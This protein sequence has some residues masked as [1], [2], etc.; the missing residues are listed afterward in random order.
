MSTRL[1]CASSAGNA[2]V[3]HMD[4][5]QESLDLKTKARKF[6]IEN[7]SEWGSVFELSDHIAKHFD[8]DASLI[9]AW[10]TVE[11]WEM[12]S[13]DPGR[14]TFVGFFDEDDPRDFANDPLHDFYHHH[15]KIGNRRSTLDYLKAVGF[16]R[17]SEV[18][19][20]MAQSL[21]Q[22]YPISLEDLATYLCVEPLLF[23]KYARANGIKEKLINRPCQP[24]LSLLYLHSQLQQVVVAHAQHL[25]KLR[26][27]PIRFMACR[28]NLNWRE[29]WALGAERGVWQ[30]PSVD[31]LR[32]LDEYF[33]S[34]KTIS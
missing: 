4:R 3:V 10:R 18:D 8:V 34:R 21:L 28:L 5:V 20:D 6:W 31:T 19:L 1:L 9:N 25:Y 29:L 32:D 33:R 23:A 15:E 16:L 7:A 24:F 13:K 26:G 12:P 22:R 11:R 27:V 14:K 30:M 17:P 2:N